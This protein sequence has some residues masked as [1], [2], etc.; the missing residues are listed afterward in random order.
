MAQPI[1]LAESLTTNVRR[2]GTKS[3]SVLKEGQ[4]RHAVQCPG[5]LFASSRPLSDGRTGSDGRI[6]VFNRIVEI[7]DSSS[8]TERFFAS[9]LTASAT[10]GN[11]EAYHA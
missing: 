9:G 7:T 5:M 8:F 6:K 1:Q 2:S 10:A 11:D 3:T 4:R